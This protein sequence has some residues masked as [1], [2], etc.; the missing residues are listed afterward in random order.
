MGTIKSIAMAVIAFFQIFG[1]LLS[2][3]VSGLVNLTQFIVDYITI[4]TKRERDALSLD[5]ETRRLAKESQALKESSNVA[6]G[7]SILDE[8]WMVRYNQIL[9]FIQKKDFASVLKVTNSF[10]NDAVNLILFNLSS[11]E[12]YRALQIVKRMKDEEK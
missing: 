1:P 5:V 4:R 2:M 10:D 9:G 7:K 6:A 12:E 3:L 11:S 8:S